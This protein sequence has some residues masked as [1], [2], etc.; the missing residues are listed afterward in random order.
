MLII[1]KPR[2]NL[3]IWKFLLQYQIIK[4]KCAKTIRAQIKINY[5]FLKSLKIRHSGA[6]SFLILYLTKVFR[7]FSQFV[8]CM[9]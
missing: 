7:L 9:L 4:Q 2:R 1:I 5:S 6:L 3:Q 8:L